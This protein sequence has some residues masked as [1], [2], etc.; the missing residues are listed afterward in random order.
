LVVGSSLALASGAFAQQAIQWRVEDGGNG[1]WYLWKPQGSFTSWTAARDAAEAAGG[2]LASIRSEAEEMFARS[3]IGAW[4]CGSV[5]ESSTA[6]GGFQPNPQD[7]ACCWQWVSGEPW[8]GWEPWTNGAPN[9]GP[10]EPESILLMYRGPGWNDGN[11]QYGPY[12]TCRIAAMFE[13]S[14]DCNNDG[15]VD[16]GQIRSG[17]LTDANGDNIPDCCQSGAACNATLV[18]WAGGLEANGH[19]YELLE[20]SSHVTWESAQSIAESRGGHLATLTGPEEN[21]FVFSLVPPRLHLPGPWIGGFQPAGS[22][23]PAGGWRWVT[24]EPFQW[25]NW[26]GLAPNNDFCGVLPEDKL[27]FFNQFGEWN[28]L[29]EAPDGCI[30]PMRSF[31][32]EYSAD[33]NGDGIVDFGQMRSGDLRDL[34]GNYVPDCC[35]GAA[36]C[37]CTA[38]VDS[39]GAVNGVDLAAILN[40]W[41]TS[42][43]KY[44]GADINADGIVDGAD[45]AEVLNSWGACP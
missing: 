16:Y 1:H 41:G 5:G 44:P 33:C 13:W 35:E 8:T 26:N 40:T 19:W 42:G 2:Y 3:V 43:G 21:F 14:A 30:P 9:N 11:I 28:D 36:S 12:W 27:H 34:N 23:E 20:Y 24:G 39:S 15:I 4:T 17:D 10:S 45:L 37:G 18:Q 38:D 22:P 31:V 6:I 7:V 25:T 32:I 29:S